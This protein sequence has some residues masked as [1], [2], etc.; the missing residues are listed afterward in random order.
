LT[1]QTSVRELGARSH[2][3]ALLAIVGPVSGLDILDVGCGEGHLAQALAERGA[4]VTG[5]DPL[6]AETPSTKHGNGSYRLVKA[7]ADAIPEP[8]R[9]TDLVLFVFSLHHVPAAKLKGA[10]IETRRV[11]RP[12]GRLYVA[13]P[14]AQGPHQYIMEL[15]HDETEVRKAAAGA[16][17]QFAGPHFAAVEIA[18]YNDTRRYSDF[19]S[20]AGRMI[21]NMRFNG[22]SEKAVLAPE[23]RRRFA[24]MHAKTAGEFDQPVRID[25]FH[26]AN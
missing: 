11:L 8:D 24:E 26:P 10:L 18:G 20:F 2:L 1:V 14:L 13:E 21:A 9:S 23:V 25:Y 15:F 5:Y 12:S 19:D 4:R 22:Y 17:A 7:P 3:D 6:I 16:L